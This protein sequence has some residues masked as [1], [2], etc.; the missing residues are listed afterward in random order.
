MRF[1]LKELLLVSMSSSSNGAICRHKRFKFGKVSYLVH[2]ELHQG[3]LIIRQ[4]KRIRRTPSLS[5]RLQKR[6]RRLNG[7][8]APTAVV[9]PPRQVAGEDGTHRKSIAV[10]ME[11]LMQSTTS[12]TQHQEWSS[13]QV[14]TSDLVSTIS[15]D[16]QTHEPVQQLSS[17]AVGTEV[18]LDSSAS[19]TLLQE[20]TSSNVDTTDLII[21]IARDQQTF[22]PHHVTLASQTDTHDQHCNTTQTDLCT[23]TSNTQTKLAKLSCLGTQTMVHC[24]TA[25]VQTKR[26]REHMG[27]QTI[28]DEE[29]LIKPHLQALYLIHDSIKNQSNLIQNEVL[30]AVNQLVDISLLQVK[31]MRVE[32]DLPREAS[33]EP[34]TPI[35]SSQIGDNP[36][37]ESSSAKNDSFKLEPKYRIIRVVKDKRSSVGRSWNCTKK[38]KGCGLHMHRTRHRVTSENQETQTEVETKDAVVRSEVATQTERERARWTMKRI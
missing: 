2:Y 1:D 21:T 7:G 24:T 10:G 23:K 9:Q 30:E 11:L 5:S 22:H 16:A 18:E 32:L 33:L 34:M 31:Q 25:T 17:I 4:V 35:P 36:P 27:T 38:C 19:Q 13:S 12:Q 3:K 29:E 28:D 8:S 6:R 26:H 14:D 37:K 20:S 15:R